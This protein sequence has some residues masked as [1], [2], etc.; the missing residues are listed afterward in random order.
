MAGNNA[1]NICTNGKFYVDPVNLQGGDFVPS[2]LLTLSLSKIRLQSNTG[3][4]VSFEA[5]NPAP[6][7]VRDEPSVNLDMGS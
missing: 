5:D 2:F 7:S 4:I 3:S 6:P 1:F